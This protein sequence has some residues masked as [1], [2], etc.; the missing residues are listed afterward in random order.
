MLTI[1][2]SD[3]ERFCDGMSRRGFLKIGGLALG[4]ASLPQI[5]QAEALEGKPH[6]LNHKAVIMVFLAGGPPHQDMWDIK[7]DAPSE[8]R[9]EFKAINTN[10]SGIQIGELFPQIAK[11]ADRYVFIRSMVGAHGG[12]DAEQ[13]LTGRAPR[14]APPGGWPSI[15]AVLSKLEGTADKAVPP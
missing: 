11:R 7:S 3:Q 5:L 14:N 15:G 8:I 1:L 9:G 2:G 13:C 12:H 4:G 10:V 6:K